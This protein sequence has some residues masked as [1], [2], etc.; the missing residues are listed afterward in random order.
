MLVY[1]RVTI[2]W[3]QNRKIPSG[4][5]PFSPISAYNA[6]KNRQS[7]SIDLVLLD[8]WYLCLKH[9]QISPG[10]SWFGLWSPKTP[11]FNTGIPHEK[12]MHWGLV[13]SPCLLRN[14]SDVCWWLHRLNKQR[15]KTS[16]STKNTK[17]LIESRLTPYIWSW[18]PFRLV[19]CS[20]DFRH[21]KHHEE[22]TKKRHKKVLEPILDPMRLDNLEPSLELILRGIGIA[23]YLWGI[24]WINR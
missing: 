14:S 16:W 20:H 15:T 2:G 3:S 18:V 22:I 9:I 13:Q 4:D 12:P 17:T 19:L 11:R 10:L 21:T 23:R 24:N 6:K 7:T 8:K 1:Q 5:A